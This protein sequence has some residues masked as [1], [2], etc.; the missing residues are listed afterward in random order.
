M[1]SLRPW[2]EWMDKVIAGLVVLG[3]LTFVVGAGWAVYRVGRA[4]VLGCSL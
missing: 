3:A 4:I 2:P 1:W